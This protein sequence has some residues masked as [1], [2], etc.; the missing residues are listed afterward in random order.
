MKVKVN[1]LVKP[2]SC[3]HLSHTPVGNCAQEVHESAPFM[4]VLMLCMSIQSNSFYPSACGGFK[5]GSE[6]CTVPTVV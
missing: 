5:G 1:V 6:R 3:I 2:H 4:Q